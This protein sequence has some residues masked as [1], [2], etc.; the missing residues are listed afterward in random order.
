M[1]DKRYRIVSDFG[2]GDKSWTERNLTEAQ[3]FEWFKNRFN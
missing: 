3:V 2:Y 1:S